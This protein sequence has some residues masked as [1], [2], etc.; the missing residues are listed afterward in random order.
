MSVYCLMS[1]VLLLALGAGEETVPKA[2][3]GVGTTPTKVK[4]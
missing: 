4:T 3:T 1:A 2:N